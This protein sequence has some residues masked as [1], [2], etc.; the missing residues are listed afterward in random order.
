MAHKQCLKKMRKHIWCDCINDD[1]EELKT[2][3]KL[4]SKYRVKNLYMKL[5]KDAKSIQKIVEQVY[6]DLK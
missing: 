3:R 1:L 2:V 4:L 6:G 5:A